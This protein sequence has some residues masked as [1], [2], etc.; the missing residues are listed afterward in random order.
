MQRSSLSRDP[1]LALTIL[2]PDRQCS[3]HPRRGPLLAGRRADVHSSRASIRNRR[4][5]KRHMCVS[6]KRTSSIDFVRYS[7]EIIHVACAPWK[8]YSLTRTDAAGHRGTASTFVEGDAALAIPEQTKTSKSATNRN[9][10]TISVS[11]AWPADNYR[12]HLV[13]DVCESNLR[14]ARTTLDIL[15]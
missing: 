6:M 2:S 10:F 7:K 4:Y 15:R 1:L 3:C 9:R 13:A 5:H 12:L 14:P 11:H 8:L